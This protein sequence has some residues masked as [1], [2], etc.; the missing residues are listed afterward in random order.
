MS[1]NSRQAFIRYAASA[2][3]G[4]RSSK[5]LPRSRRRGRTGREAE[6]RDGVTPVLTGVPSG[7]DESGT[8]ESVISAVIRFIAG[9]SPPHDPVFAMRDPDRD[10]G[11]HST[12]SHRQINELAPA[13]V[14]HR[15][16]V[17]VRD[18]ASASGMC[19]SPDSSA[20]RLRAG[21]RT[22]Q[23]RSV[24]TSDVVNTIAPNNDVRAVQPTAAD[25]SRRRKPQ[26]SPE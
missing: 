21:N 17:S 12:C 4:Y 11:V 19:S 1:R 9:E 20:T 16:N 23:L 22:C 18:C 8:L 26:V 2:R 7:H 15:R 6:R 3:S 10:S 14:M 5:A 13:L 25:G 24:S